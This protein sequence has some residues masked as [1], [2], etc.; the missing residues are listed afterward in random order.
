MRTAGPY[1]VCEQCDTVHVRP[2][3]GR[4]D[5]LRCTCCNARLIHHRPLGPNRLLALAVAALIVFVI[6]NI[7]PIMTLS[8]Q[9]HS[10]SST[11]WEA[12]AA[13]YAQGRF[14]IAFLAASTMFFAPLIELLTLIHIVL[15]LREHKQPPGLTPAMTVLKWL[16]PWDMVDVFVLG[17][18]ITVSKI[19]DLATVIPGIGLYAFGALTLLIVGMKT[20]TIRDLW[21][22]ADEATA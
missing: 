15:S 11:L 4:N 13:S 7:Y 16:R 17:S 6:A 19:G 18:L 22:M 14:G 9:G 20:I 2:P 5:R 12:I 10:S 1:L 3:I 21:D 8:I